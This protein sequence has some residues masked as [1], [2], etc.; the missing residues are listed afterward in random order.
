MDQ[1]LTAENF[2]LLMR[3]LPVADLSGGTIAV[4]VSGGADS[5]ALALMLDDWCRKRKVDLLALTVNHG[6]RPEAGRECEQVRTWL[7][8][9]DIPQ[10]T[11]TW[12][13]A[14]PTSSI[15]EGA[16][17]IR[18]E[19]LGRR[20]AELGIKYLFLAHH[21]DDQAETFLLRLARGSGVDG[22]AAMRRTAAFPLRPEDVMEDRL[23][24]LCRPL[25]DCNKKQLVAYLASC[26]QDWIEDPSNQDMKHNR[27]Q[28]REFLAHTTI[29]GLTT[30]RLADT[31]K[32]MQAVQNLLDRLTDDLYQLGVNIHPQGY[33]E[34]T[35]S[36]L[37]AAE[38]EIAF[39][40]LA[41]VLK[42]VSGSEFPPRFEKTRNL[43]ERLATGEKV[44]QTIGGCR[45]ILMQPELLL[46]V[47]EE[48]A[49]AGERDVTAGEKVLWDG[50]FRLDVPEE[51]R[52]CKLG[53]TG[54]RELSRERPELKQNSALKH[55]IPALPCLQTRAGEKIRPDVLPG[56]EKKT[57]RAVF[58]VPGD[59]FTEKK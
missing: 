11:L 20:C 17:R 22:L 47:R 16:R 8:A 53:Q 57:F 50:R 24:V 23:P 35:M 34:V 13:Q 3:D 48:A 28:V 15:Q 30:A 4:A 6:L 38:Q 41:R 5:M 31:A 43:H 39:R 42:L 45:V 1:P 51:G 29:T 27:V 40:L 49:V 18:Y 21:Q 12:R 14:T 37:L 59:N 55:A 25:L 26:G 9:L 32:R 36:A 19:L 33:A 2:D 7:A 52:I 58:R 56:E 46:V 44:D 10:E 54:W